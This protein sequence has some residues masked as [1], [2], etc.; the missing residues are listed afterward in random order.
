MRRV[1]AMLCAASYD[2]RRIRY[3][4]AGPKGPLPSLSVPGKRSWSGRRGSN[5]RPR[6]WQGRALPLSYARILVGWKSRPPGGK[7]GDNTG[8]M[9]ICKRLKSQR[10]PVVN[11]SLRQV[12]VEFGFYGCLLCED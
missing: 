3:R 7:W 12:A 6:P 4:G 5:P 1:D 11:V 9:G 2:T 8:E 10:L